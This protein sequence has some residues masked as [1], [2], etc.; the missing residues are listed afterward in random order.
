MLLREISSSFKFFSC[1]SHP[2]DPS[3]HRHILKSFLFGATLNI[4]KM[5]FNVNGVS[6]RSLFNV[7]MLN[8]SSEFLKTLPVILFHCAESC[9]SDSGGA[10]FGISSSL[11]FQNE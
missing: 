2:I 7:H 5:A 6:E 4:L 1:G 10:S 3:S 9:Q 8:D 11:R